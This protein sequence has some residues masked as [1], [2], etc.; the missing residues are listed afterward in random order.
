M[1]LSNITKR[2]I[3]IILFQEFQVVKTIK[4]SKLRVIGN[5]EQTIETF[6]IRDVDE[7]IIL[8]IEASKKNYKINLDVLKSLSRNANMPFSFGGGVKTLNDVERILKNGADKVVI[9]NQAIKNLK[10]I[11]EASRKFGKQCIV[12]AVDYKIDGD[13]FL[14]YSHSQKKTLDNDIFEYLKILE[15]SGA[16]EILL[17]SVDNDGLMKGFEMELIKKIHKTRIPII[18]SGGCGNPQHIK[19]AFE[20]NVDAVAAGSVFYFSHFS[21]SDLKQYL[22]EHKQNIRF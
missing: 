17:S 3:P 4:F 7:I 21:Y 15:D 12:S 10:F 20:N 9:N 11:E 16:G 14:L 6:N 8:D 1:K 19:I 18:L 13:K 2:I 22:F 5:F